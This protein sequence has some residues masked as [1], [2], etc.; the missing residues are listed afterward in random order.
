MHAGAALALLILL[1]SS[2]ALTSPD[3]CHCSVVGPSGLSLDCRAK[4]LTDVPP[5]LPSTKELYLQDNKLTTVQ[6]G[7]LDTLHSLTVVNLSGNPWHCGCDIL[8]LKAWLE[9]HGEVAGIPTCATPPNLAHKSITKLTEE[10]LPECSQR[11]C[12]STW[13]DI[14]T[15]LLF[16]GLVTMLL[17]CLWTTK[18][19]SLTIILDRRHHGIVS[20]V[21]RSFRPK[22]ERKPKSRSMEVESTLEWRDDLQRPLVNME[23]LP[24][25]ID[26]LHKKHNI[27]IKVT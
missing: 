4:G 2:E 3:S 19:S 12:K 21:P 5:V 9:D 27:K 25:I 16:C 14:S 23:I 7:R 15:I 26:S 6:P 17:W 11:H 18:N 10:N 13:L 20:N 22:Y 24:Q 1:A 8:Y